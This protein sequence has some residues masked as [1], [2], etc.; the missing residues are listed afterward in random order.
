MK[1]INI[2][3]VDG[4][5]GGIGGIIVEKLRA[6]FPKINILALGTN[7]VAT[8]KML[9]AGANQ[10]ATGENAV[11]YNAKNVD[12]IMGV[13]AILMPNAMMG[14]LSPRMAEAIGSSD[15]MKILIPLEK[16]NIR[17]AMPGDNNL[18]KCVEHSLELVKKHIEGNNK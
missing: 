16:C 2:A 8:G 17:I 12:I 6:E 14:E 9:K 10:G 1:D 18:G 13:V 5:G 4:Q 15:A 7:S 11:I 3:V